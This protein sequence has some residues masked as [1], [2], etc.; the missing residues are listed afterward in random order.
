MVRRITSFGEIKQ[1]I[2]YCQKDMLYQQAYKIGKNFIE[3][4]P[5]PCNGAV[6]FDIDDTLLKVGVNCSLT[7][8]D[9]IINL[10]KLCKR[11]GYKILIITA[12]PLIT[13]NYRHAVKNL[14]D[15]DIP[16]DELILRPPEMLPEKY[17]PM[18]KEKLT[19]SNFVTIVM[20]VGDQEVD[21][22]GDNSG[23]RILLPSKCNN[24]RLI[25]D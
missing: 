19:K 18:V 21:I 20:S 8:I 13:D 17:K 11:K 6:M 23:F 5:K 10:L 9:S 16:Y 24:Y 1:D 15:N 3:S 22:S 14:N 4:I 7:P 25:T 12:R 2:V